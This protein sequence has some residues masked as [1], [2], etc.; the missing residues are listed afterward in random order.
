VVSPVL[1]LCNELTYLIATI[2]NRQCSRGASAEDRHYC[3]IEHLRD[4]FGVLRCALRGCILCIQP[5]E[6]TRR[7]STTMLMRDDKR[8]SALSRWC[9]GWD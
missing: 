7:K 3:K 9:S 1:F 2:D 5:L 4:Y 8:R 6:R